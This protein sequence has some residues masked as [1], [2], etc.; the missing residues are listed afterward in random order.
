MA[1][2]GRRASLTSSL[3]E[4][5]LYSRFLSSQV[6]QED[7]APSTQTHFTPGSGTA[8]PTISSL[9]VRGLWHGQVV[10]RG[11]REPSNRLSECQKCRLWQR[12]LEIVL[13]TR[14]KQEKLWQQELH[15]YQVAVLEAEARKGELERAQQELFRLA[16]GYDHDSHTTPRTRLTFTQLLRF[17]EDQVRGDLKQTS[18][19]WVE[20]ALLRAHLAKLKSRLE[21]G[22]EGPDADPDTQ[23]TSQ[24]N[25]L[26][27]QLEHEDVKT[28]VDHNSR[29][30]THLLR[31]LEKERRRANRLAEEN[32][33]KTTMVGELKDQEAL[34]QEEVRRLSQSSTR[35]D[36]HVRLHDLRTD[37]R[38]AAVRATQDPVMT[39]EEYLCLNADVHKL[40][41]EVAS[42]RNKAD[43][44][45]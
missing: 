32:Q 44:L 5:D 19:V 25:F 45:H 4:L 17:M 21:Q 29:T 23:P 31:Q 26:K 20:V 2:E 40:Q 36:A 8:T 13:A 34:L 10:T 41:K 27:K 7:A 24:V 30:L 35:I 38:L 22:H 39:V 18:Q 28:R 1:G 33:A 6:V 3:A 9:D 12:E 14:R 43:A 15:K 16:S 42:W 11:R 37:K